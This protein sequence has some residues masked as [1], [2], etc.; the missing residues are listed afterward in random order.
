MGN[1]ERKENGNY[2]LQSWPDNA[3]YSYC[4]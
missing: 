3:P 1:M 4:T 2:K